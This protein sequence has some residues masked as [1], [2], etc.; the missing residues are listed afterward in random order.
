MTRRTA[1]SKA[2]MVIM[3]RGLM[4]SSMQVCSAATARRTSA[5]FSGCSPPSSPSSRFISGSHAARL[6]ERQALLVVDLAGDEL[7][8]GLEGRD[9]VE[10][11]LHRRPAAR[12]DSASVDH[13]RGPVDAP[14]GHDAA[15]HVLV[16]AGDGEV[17]VV[18][19]RGHHRLDAVGDQV[20]ALQ[21]V[22]HAVGAVGD[23]VADTD[24]VEAHRHHAELL[25]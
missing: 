19:L 8:V 11:L 23:T 13:D 25:R 18:E 1:F 2:F 15:G 22:G 6:D 10:L 17:G 9:D 5:T 4:S 21:G 16:A 14:H 20:A 12:P 7:P 3:S 24:A